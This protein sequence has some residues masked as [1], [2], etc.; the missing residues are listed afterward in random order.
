VEAL[1]VATLTRVNRLP[2]DWRGPDSTSDALAD[3]TSRIRFTHNMLRRPPADRWSGAA[4]AA[5]TCA[6]CLQAAIDCNMDASVRS[7]HALKL[8]SQH[9]QLSANVDGRLSHCQD[10]RQ[11]TSGTAATT[12]PAT[13][14]AATA[15]DRNSRRPQLSQTA[16]AADTPA[17]GAS[18]AAPLEAGA[19][20]D[21][22]ATAKFNASRHDKGTSTRYSE[23]ELLAQEQ[24]GRDASAG[25]CGAALA[26][27]AAGVQVAWGQLLHV[28]ETADA[29]AAADAGQARLEEQAKQSSGHS[30]A[31]DGSQG[32]KFSSGPPNSQGKAAEAESLQDCWLCSLMKPV[33]TAGMYK[34]RTSPAGQAPCCGCKAVLPTQQL[35]LHWHAW[36]WRRSYKCMA[37][38]LCQNCKCISFV[39][40]APDMFALWTCRITAGTAPASDS[41]ATS[42]SWRCGICAPQYAHRVGALLAMIFLNSLRASSLQRL[43]SRHLRMV[44]QATTTVAL[45]WHKHY[46]S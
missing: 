19:A 42:G 6:M 35:L 14:G 37:V 7:I 11:S 34:A 46:T 8:C 5:M 22:A 17:R 3:N 16:T 32:Q 40:Y 30:I 31:D 44:T 26:D 29:A 4:L 24:R 41:A 2:A 33:F 9:G 25:D 39:P 28:N 38:H 15:A 27:A 43:R 45:M 21:V 36:P 1:D 13:S 12:V 10:G 18:G 23:R 20:A